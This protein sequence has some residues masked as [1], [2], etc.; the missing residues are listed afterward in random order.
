MQQHVAHRSS[1]T[2]D[3]AVDEI[4]VRPG[5]IWA[6]ISMHFAFGDCTITR[7]FFRYK[8]KELIL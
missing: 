3:T 4:T 8:P 1:K 2:T 7:I 5:P 6:A